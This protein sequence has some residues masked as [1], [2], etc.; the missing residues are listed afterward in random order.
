M[1]EITGGRKEV[2]YRAWLDTQH[3]VRT[4]SSRRAV[5]EA[6]IEGWQRSREVLLEK[7]SEHYSVQKY[8]D[9]RS[10][11]PSV[12]VV[13]EEWITVVQFRKTVDDAKEDKSLCEQKFPDDTFRI[14]RITRIEE[15]L[16]DN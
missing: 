4:N 13:G 14:V 8:V 12:H 5:H 1:T 11:F 10:R 6:W 2:E 3:I 16:T 15:L 9:Q 7:G